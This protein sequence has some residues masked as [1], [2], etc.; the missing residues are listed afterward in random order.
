LKNTKK[1]DNNMSRARN[2]ERRKV[3]RKRKEAENE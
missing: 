2:Y 1:A 3:Q